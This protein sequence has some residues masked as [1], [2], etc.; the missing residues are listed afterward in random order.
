L[1]S[2]FGK[3]ERTR[4]RDVVVDTPQVRLLRRIMGKPSVGDELKGIDSGIRTAKHWR[5]AA[6]FRR[7][8]AK[9]EIAYL[10]SS[11]PEH[12]ERQQICQKAR[13]AGLFDSYHQWS[14]AHPL[15][16][17]LEEPAC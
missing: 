11:D 14:S 4:V 16:Q 3:I 5:T 15:A 10:L 6:N 8:L 2:A 9:A 7:A 13:F 12:L 17:D 1:W